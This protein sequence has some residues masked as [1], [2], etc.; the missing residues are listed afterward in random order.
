[1]NIFRT[2]LFENPYLEVEETV[3]EVGKAEHMAAGYEA[4][5]KSIV[6][7]KNKE[8]VLPLE[9]GSTVFIPKRMTHPRRRFFGPAQAPSLQDPFNM[10]VVGKYF[11]VTEDPGEADFALVRIES[12]N[13]GAG[14]D[15]AD[16]EAGGNGYV[17]ISLQYDEYTAEHAR[18]TSI[19][20]GDPFEDFTNRSYRGKSVT[21]VNASDLALVRD[22][23]EA[24][25]GKPLVVLIS[26]SKPM[27]F[28]EFET[29]VNAILV[30][31]G[32]QDQAVLDVLTGKAEPSGLL[33]MQMP[34]NMRT[35]EEQKED[36]PHDMDGHVD[37]EGHTYDFGFG[38]GWEGA[39]EGA[40]T[41]RYRK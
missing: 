33:P 16:R 19:A 31:F 21:T 11:G 7:V 35:V 13:G 37:S 14:Y 18:E 12:P 32:V 22:T 29:D 36:V 4:Q 24:M 26:M 23:R 30:A 41:A 3:K 34:A 27:V 38:L 10:E 25:S 5:L 2:G 20:G 6:M 40:R 9:K 17:P 8:A 1:M 39:I 15:R 28:E